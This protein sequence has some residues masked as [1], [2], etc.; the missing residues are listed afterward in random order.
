MMERVSIPMQF[1]QQSGFHATD[2]FL[3]ICS[4]LPVI[5]YSDGINDV[6][7]L[8]IHELDQVMLSSDI[9]PEEVTN[10]LD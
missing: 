7:I 5:L 4:W 1:L 6:D 3:A 8:I 10:Q 9:S 2:S